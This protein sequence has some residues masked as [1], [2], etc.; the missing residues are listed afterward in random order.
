MNRDKYTWHSVHLDRD[1]T[2]L[3]YGTK[4]VPVLAFPSKTTRCDDWEKNGMVDSIEKYLEEGKIQLFAVQSV[5]DESWLCENGIN[6]WRTARQESYYR[7][8]IE[9]VLSFIHKKNKSKKLPIV[10]GTQ[11]GANQA[12]IMFLRRPDLFQSVIALSGIYDAR[13]FFGYYI[14]HDLYE[15]SPERFLENMAPD[16]QYIE[17]YNK[18]KMI[19]C[20]GQGA[21]EFDGVRALKNLERIFITKSINAWCDYWGYDVSHSWDWWRKQIEYF[22]PKVLETDKDKDKTAETGSG[23]KKEAAP[24]D[25][26]ITEIDVSEKKATEDRASKNTVTGTKSVKSD[27]PLKTEAGSDTAKTPDAK[28]KTEAVKTTDVKTKAEAVKTTDVK[29]IAEAVK[30]SDVKSKD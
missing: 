15:N 22:L 8:I 10:A 5:D 9:D 29:A 12:A 19:F 28:A 18:R 17:I 1:M 26:K 24:S 4:G 2:V 7:Y 16:H 6:V 13:Y 14:D 3:V 25:G 21:Q 11:M 27:K 23:E 30:V 20:V